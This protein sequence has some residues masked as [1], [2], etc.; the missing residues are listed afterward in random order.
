MNQESENGTK[1]GRRRLWRWLLAGTVLLSIVSVMAVLKSDDALL[2]YDDLKVAETPV[3]DIRTN[4][5]LY[6]REKWGQ[7]PQTG[8]QERVKAMING[9]EPPDQAFVDR[10]RKGRANSVEDWRTA[11]AMP[12]WRLPLPVNT[13]VE[14]GSWVLLPIQLLVFDAMAPL[15]SG[16]AGPA[17]SLQQ[18]V[19]LWIKRH[20]AGGGGIVSVAVATRPQEMVAD[21]GCSVLSLSNPDAGQLEAMDI[22]WREEPPIAEA[23]QS[24]VR[25]DAAV[26][27]RILD[28]MKSDSGQLDET[29]Y[30]V[31]RREKLFLK[32]N[33]TLNAYHEA[34]RKVVAAPFQPFPSLEMAWQTGYGKLQRDRPL[35]GRWDPNATGERILSSLGG[36]GTLALWQ[37]KALFIP[38]AMRVRLAVHRWRQT[39]P[40]QWPST[41]AE[42]VP[43][44]LA[45]VPQDPWNGAPLLWDQ[46]ARTVYAVG[47]DWSPDQPD[48]Q[49]DDRGWTV[50]NPNTPGL[51]ME[52]PL[53]NPAARSKHRVVRGSQ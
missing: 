36:S 31:T 29:D 19:A 39:H 9:Q 41:L 22:L 13:E 45:E 25:K 20:L 14:T 6:L 47:A 49:P 24:A 32:K 51:R 17:N 42:L 50:Y 35:L 33:R 53:V 10:L 30:S 26:V 1:P 23:L 37:Y 38:R 3:P 46:A 7:W 15:R 48:F 16:D 27:R 43:D 40:G 18:E 12:E 52:L 28:L 34:L 21:L 5:Y 2:P 44:F 11:L 4:G 8:P